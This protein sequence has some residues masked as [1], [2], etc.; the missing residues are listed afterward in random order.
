MTKT[1]EHPR[2]PAEGVE[3]GS[4]GPSQSGG[5]ILGN[6]RESETAPLI[7]PPPLLQASPGP[8]QE[9]Q[10]LGKGL[11]STGREAHAHWVPL[12]TPTAS[13]G[14]CGEGGPLFLSDPFTGDYVVPWA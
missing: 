13:G 11:V 9:A 2:G 6:I 5:N 1:T 10:G 8:G 4:P 3:A 14:P 7:A 12:G